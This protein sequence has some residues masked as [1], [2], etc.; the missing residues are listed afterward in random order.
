MLGDLLYFVISIICGAVFPEK[1]VAPIHFG[2]ISTCNASP[3]EHRPTITHDT[4]QRASADQER[5]TTMM[6]FAFS[7]TTGSSQKVNTAARNDRGSY[8]IASLPK[9]THI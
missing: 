8:R 4:N 7:S 5:N 2:F 3:S 9:L 6:G 1:M